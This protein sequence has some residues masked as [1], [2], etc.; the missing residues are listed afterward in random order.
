MDI[1][2]F[3][4]LEPKDNAPEKHE[5]ITVEWAA[6]TIPSER[7]P[8]RNEDTILTNEEYKTFGIFDGV[9]GAPAGDLAS[10]VARDYISTHLKEIHDGKDVDI[11]KKTLSAIIVKADEAVYEASKNNV[12]YQNM[13]TTTSLVKIYTDKKGKNYALIANV[14]DSRA[15]K[16]GKDKK[17]QQI[18]VDDGTVSESFPFNKE[19]GLRVAERIAN[20][21]K[22][23]D[24]DSN[25][26]INYFFRMRNRITKALGTKENSQIDVDI[27]P[28]EKGES[29][30][31][32][33]DGIHDNLTTDEIQE[34]VNK[35]E[36]ISE[37]VKNL[38]DESLARSREPEE[39][40]IRAKPD[41]MSVVLIEVK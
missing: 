9:G 32:T 31:I 3:P 11:A 5:I 25:G 18:T 8:E 35:F 41:D 12:D 26:E 23:E 27:I 13:F 2:K 36:S 22:K 29:F 4:N 37:I 10:K 16:I 19:E 21:R 20:V 1:D 6:E 39:K 14:G 38:K 33:S 40:E 15:Y 28:V 17:L 30:L 34:I 7:H 24:L